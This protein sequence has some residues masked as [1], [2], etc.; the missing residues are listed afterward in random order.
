VLRADGPDVEPHLVADQLRSVDALQQRARDGGFV[1]GFVRGQRG[2]HPVVVS[3]LDEA[4]QRGGELLQAVVRRAGSAFVFVHER[5]IHQ[6]R[7]ARRPRRDGADAERR[8][9]SGAEFAGEEKCV[10]GSTRPTVAGLDFARR[11]DG[12]LPEAL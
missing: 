2:F 4:A 11:V 6:P 8:L 3:Q 5:L 10:V 1:R 12:P 7:V 9:Q